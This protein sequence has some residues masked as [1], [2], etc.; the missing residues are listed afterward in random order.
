M[1]GGATL[2]VA[3]AIK[4]IAH[5]VVGGGIAL[6][7]FAILFVPLE[8]VFRARPRVERRPELL[9]D[10]L[11]YFFQYAI[12]AGGVSWLLMSLEVLVEPVLAPRRGL[13]DALPWAAKFVIAWF[14]GDLLL[15]W[16]H[17]LQ[18][19]VPLLWRFH[20][21]HHT[22]EEVDWLASFR[23]HPVDGLYTRL[24]ANLPTILIGFSLAE[25]A[26]LLT[27]RGLWASFIHANVRLSVGPLK[28]LFGAPQL[29]RW[30]HEITSGGRYNFAN[31]MPLMDV[32][33]GTYHDP[34]HPPRRFGVEGWSRRGYWAHILGPFKP[35][36]RSVDVD[37]V[38]IEDR[39]AAN[40]NVAR[41]AD[42]DDGATGRPRLRAGH[43]GLG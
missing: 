1:T 14:A 24:L 40:A 20:R 15:Y 33:F 10:I 3:A 11:F 41:V 17:R 26:G 21:V 22:A 13:I 38:L 32:I 23:E 25:I 12:W 27:L 42:A 16:G 29:H 36:P 18:H 34:G 31:L 39:V 7:V 2:S 35:E 37:T 6:V 5:T 8:R 28:Y 30:H 19:R 43:A 9:L 4:E